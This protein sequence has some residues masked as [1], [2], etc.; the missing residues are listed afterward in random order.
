M[1]TKELFSYGNGKTFHG[2]AALLATLIVSVLAA[3]GVTIKETDVL[4][5]LFGVWAGVGVVHKIW[6]AWR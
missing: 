4:A 6:K 2:V 5:G 1:D 3:K